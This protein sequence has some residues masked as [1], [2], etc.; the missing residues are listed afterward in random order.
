MEEIRQ[1]IDRAYVEGIH[2]T[3]DED[4]IRAGFDDEFRIYVKG[5]AGVTPLDVSGWLDRVAGLKA[6]QPELWR[7]PTNVVYDA[8]DIAGD[9]AS[10]KL[11]VYKGET[12]FA[13]DFILLY[14]LDDGWRMVAKV[15]TL[16]ETG[17]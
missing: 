8:I 3:Q 2:T 5:P 15:F 16:A 6:A 13:T 11:T 9:C 14:R 17:G 7:Q 10:V 1:V 4:S 12:Y